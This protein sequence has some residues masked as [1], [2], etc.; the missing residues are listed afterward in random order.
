MSKLLLA[1]LLLGGALSSFAAHDEV[2]YTKPDPYTMVGSKNLFTDFA[3]RNPDGTITAVVEIPAGTTDKW[4]VVVT[5]G[6]LHWELE[7]GEPRVVKYLGYP[8]NYGMLPRTVLCE[9]EGGDGDPLDVVVLGPAL[10]RGAVVR[11]RVLGTLR[12]R[13]RGERDDK[14]LAVIEGTALAEAQDL[15]EL[16][17]MFPGAT[18]IVETWFRNY[19]GPG[20]VETDGCGGLDEAERLL[21]SAIAAF[22][23]EH[24]PEAK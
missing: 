2:R 15:A 3:P 9:A 7:K 24:A 19:K 23:R 8:G 16:D 12:M 4:E 18:A 13:D 22:E 5:D 11:A 1:A 6:T 10:E 17:L 21:A 20:A 14:L